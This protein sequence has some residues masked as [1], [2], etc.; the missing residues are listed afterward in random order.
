MVV[1]NKA[2]FKTQVGPSSKV[3]QKAGRFREGKEGA[4]VLGE[5]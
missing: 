2:L 4:E 3:V 5:C 1:P